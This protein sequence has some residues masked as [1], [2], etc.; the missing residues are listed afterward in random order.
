MANMHDIARMAGVSIGTVSNVLSGS[1][2][3]REP[4][5]Q[6]VLAAVAAKDYQ[7][8]QLARGL[9][10]VKMDT[11]AHRACIVIRRFQG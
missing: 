7:P 10:R 5:R 11:P 3:V 1:V 9:R 2:T 4:L 8:S 6:R